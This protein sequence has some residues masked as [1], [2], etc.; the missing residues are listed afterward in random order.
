MFNYQVTKHMPP[1][2]QLKFVKVQFQNI[3]ANMN[4]CLIIID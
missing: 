1:V 2:I 3:P 4:E